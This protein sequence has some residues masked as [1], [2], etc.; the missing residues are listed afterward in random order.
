MG[1]GDYRAYRRDGQAV[2]ETVA[3]GGEVYLAWLEDNPQS[4]GRPIVRVQRKD[5][6]G[7]AMSASSPLKKSGPRHH[8]QEGDLARNNSIF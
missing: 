8:P 6:D 4:P 5:E 2:L 3:A 1:G 7:R